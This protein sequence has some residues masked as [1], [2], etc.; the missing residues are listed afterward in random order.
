MGFFSTDFG[1][2]YF[3]FQ[4]CPEF[5]WPRSVDDVFQPMSANVIF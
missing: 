5:L 3:F 2:G 4:C 1:W